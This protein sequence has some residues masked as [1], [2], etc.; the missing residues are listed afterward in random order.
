[1]VMSCIC[2]P[3]DNMQDAQDRK[4]KVAVHDEDRGA[5][6]QKPHNHKDAAW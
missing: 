3:D 4:E 1:M 2:L 6:F 5:A